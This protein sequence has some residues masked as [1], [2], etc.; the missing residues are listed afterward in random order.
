MNE[1]E[2][3][4]KGA[5]SVEE[6][7]EWTGLS[8]VYIRRAIKSGKLHAVRAGRRILVPEESAQAFLRSLPKAS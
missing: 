4:A 7:A 2:P 5:R 1:K 3:T 6:T 8:E